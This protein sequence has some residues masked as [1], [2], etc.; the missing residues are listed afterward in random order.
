MAAAVE[1]AAKLGRKV[2][3]HAHGKQGIIDA[4]EAGVAT[5]EHGTFID[6]EVIELMLD[7][8]VYLVPTIAVGYLM[9]KNGSEN[10]IPEFMLEKTRKTEQ[11]CAE[12]LRRAIR[13]GVLTAFGTDAGTNYNYHGQ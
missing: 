2:A 4:I 13:A 1:E 5:I 3:A 7:R 9:L 6:D 12:N 10:G 11:E 8:G